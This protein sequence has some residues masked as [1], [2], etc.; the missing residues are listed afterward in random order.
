MQRVQFF[1]K[2][3]KVQTFNIN[4]QTVELEMNEKVFPPSEYGAQALANH[5]VINKGET[6]IDIGTGAGILAILA[7]QQGGKVYATDTDK[8]AV[9]LTK[10]NAKRNDVKVQVAQGEHFASYKRKFDVIVANLPQ[11]IVHMKYQRAI[12]KKLTHSV[13]GGPN[14]NTHMLELLRRA[15]KHMHKKSRFYMCAYTLSDYLTT[16]EAMVHDYH[17]RLIW[18]NSAS[19]KEH[20]TNNIQWYKKLDDTGKIRLYRKNR[21]WMADVFFFELTLP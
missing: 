10:K 14:G 13:S 2:K 6:V 8:D 1:L 20:V 9:E 4:G 7:A 5:V 19:P 12:G 17:T 21:Q 15:K 3:Q 11:E 18:V 16:M